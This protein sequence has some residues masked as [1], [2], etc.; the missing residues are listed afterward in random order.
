[1]PPLTVFRRVLGP[2]LGAFGPNLL[3]VTRRAS[4]FFD[5]LLCL[6]LLVRELDDSRQKSIQIHHPE[7]F[8]IAKIAADFGNRALAHCLVGYR[9]A[10]DRGDY[11]FSAMRSANFSF[12]S[13]SHLF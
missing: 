4:D 13:R 2:H 12:G 7:R 10:F 11:F 8:F 9:G 3:P 1:M 5:E 6:V